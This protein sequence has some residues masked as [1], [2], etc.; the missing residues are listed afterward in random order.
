MFPWN[1]IR[2]STMTAGASESS[3]VVADITGDGKADVVM[4]DETGNL[5][6]IDGATGAMLAGFPIQL[7]A[8]VKGPAAL[9]DCDGDGMTE[10]V[11]AGWD[12]NIYMWDY[13]HP[14][15]P[16]GP[17]PWPQFHHDAERTGNYA[18]PILLDAGGAGGAP[19]ALEFGS[20][21]PNPAHAS[22]RL[23]WG[24]PRDQAGAPYEVAV[25]DL[26]GRR[27]Q[28]VER[29]TASAGRFST[30]WNLRDAGGAPVGNGVYFLRIQVGAQSASRKL[31]VVH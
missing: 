28:T 4:G 3:P 14:F 6:A 26:T 23:Q 5:S 24:V 2:Y 1:N 22:M 12:R 11:V 30:A 17:P 27:V 29:G 31:V 25:F 13:D 21:W 20:P 19:L 18:T 9:C 10:I 15:S 16:G 8:E 7:E